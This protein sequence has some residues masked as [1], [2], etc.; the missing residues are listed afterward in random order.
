MQIWQLNATSNWQMSRTYTPGLIF[1]TCYT[2]PE[3]PLF[4]SFHTH[5]TTHGT[6]EWKG[7]QHR[8]IRRLEASHII[9]GMN[10]QQHCASSC[11]SELLLR[12]IS[13]SLSTGCLHIGH[14][15]VWYLRTFAQPLHIH[16][17]KA[18]IKFWL[19]HQEWNRFHK[20][21]KVSIF[22]ISC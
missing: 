19:Y 20:E 15:L 6:N 17:N 3:K 2:A 18:R 9:H 21:V 22:G 8:Q 12:L 14:R 16:W 10:H 11:C 13:S 4:Q 5:K 7:L 1:S